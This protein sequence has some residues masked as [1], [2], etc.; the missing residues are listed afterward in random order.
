MKNTESLLWR[1]C[2]R[3]KTRVQAWR[4][5]IQAQTEAILGNSWP[6][7]FQCKGQKKKK[8]KRRLRKCSIQKQAR[9]TRELNANFDSKLDSFAIKAITGAIDKTWIIKHWDRSNT[10]G[11]IF[12]FWSSHCG[13]AGNCLCRQQTLE[14]SGVMG[15]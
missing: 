8:I 10:F 9:K 12:W 6:S 2:Q 1:V 11:L 13:Y 15:H 7:V 14:Y 4:D 5:I 3:Y